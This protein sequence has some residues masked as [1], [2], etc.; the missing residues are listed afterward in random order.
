[1]SCIDKVPYS[2]TFTAN[3]IINY[4]LVREYHEIHFIF[5][6]HFVH[7]CGISNPV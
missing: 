4:M 3:T 6:N 2:K 7:I 5:E 1:M